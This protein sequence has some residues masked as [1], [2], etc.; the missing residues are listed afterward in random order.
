MEGFLVPAGSDPVPHDPVPLATR[1][2]AAAARATVLAPPPRGTAWAFAPVHPAFDPVLDPWVLGRLRLLVPRTCGAPPEEDG[3]DAEDGSGDDV[4]TPLGGGLLVR[5]EQVR[6]L[7][8]VPLPRS[9][10]EPPASFVT[11]AALLAVLREVGPATFD[12]E[13]TCD[14]ILVEIEHRLAG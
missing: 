11:T 6:G 7:S 5:D 10:F 3:D 13:E 4:G 8:V 14:R 12:V 2:T 9:V 1:C